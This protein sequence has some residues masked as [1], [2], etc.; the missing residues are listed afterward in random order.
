MHEV[1]CFQDEKIQMLQQNVAI[2]NIIFQN[3]N[4]IF[5]K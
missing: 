4:F 3:W 1:E 2:I 5:C